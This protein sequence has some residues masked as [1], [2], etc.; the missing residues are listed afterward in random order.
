MLIH[1]VS[2]QRTIGL[3]IAL[4]VATA[5]ALY[6]LVNVFATG[7]KEIGSEV[8]LAPNRKPY[9]DDETLETTRLDRSLAAGVGTLALISLALPLYW[10]G[11]P[12]RQEGYDIFTTEQ[13]ALRGEGQYEE[14][15]S[16]CHGAGA[17]GGGAAYTILDEEG[18]FVSSVNWTAPALNTVLYRFSIEELTHILNYGRPQSPM[19]A[20][21]APGGGPLTSQ[22]LEELIEYL[23]T[24]QLTPEEMT[25]EIRDGVRD[26]V[27]AP[28]REATAEASAVLRD[29]GATDDEKDDAAADVAAAFDELIEGLGDAVLAND[30]ATVNDLVDAYIEGLVPAAYGDLLYNNSAGGGAYGCARCHTPGASWGADGLLVANPDLEGLVQPE[31]AGGGAFGPSLLSVESQFASAGSHAAF[32]SLGC[33]ENQQ[34]GNNG[35]CEPSGQ[36]PG[37]GVDSTELEGALLSPEQIAAIVA[38]ERGLE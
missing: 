19:P 25:E 34:Y 24:I 38:Y 14:L 6:V 37:F 1:A 7:R 3:V 35:V 18:R 29:D 10:L 8:E 26:G 30:G 13:F 32:V 27:M 12:G 11:E 36:M 21:G 20:W 33:T 9:Y 5:F 28:V 16:A 4:I 22:R 2:T 17:V 15:C 31:I 23:K